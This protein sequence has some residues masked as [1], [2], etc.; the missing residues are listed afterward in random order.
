VV[1]V[2]ARAV[3]EP[4]EVAVGGQGSGGPA[5]VDDLRQDHDGREE[6]GD[7]VVERNRLEEVPQKA[8]PVEGNAD[9]DEGY[10]PAGGIR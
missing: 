10:D 1:G 4:V 9:Q 3:E 2:D 8:G 6:V 7:L 5:A